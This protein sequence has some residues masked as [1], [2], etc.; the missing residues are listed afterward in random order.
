[1]F[2]SVGRKCLFIFQSIKALFFYYCSKKAAEEIEQ[3]FVLPDIV[4][5]R[6]T[7]ASRESEVTL[8]CVLKFFNFQ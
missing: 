6:L 8:P 7:I 3:D 2:R 5:F 1:V 4:L